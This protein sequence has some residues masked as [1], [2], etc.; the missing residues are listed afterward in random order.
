MSKLKQ[1]LAEHGL[2][3][4][5]VGELAGIGS[6]R[7]SDFCNGLMPPEETRQRIAAAIRECTGKPI[8]V[9]DLWPAQPAESEK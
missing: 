4:K 5:R 1:F 7:M 3:Q 8:T 2:M 6:N 9:D